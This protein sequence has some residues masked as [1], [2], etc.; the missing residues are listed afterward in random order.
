MNRPTGVTILAVLH[1]LGAGFAVLCGFGFLFGGT[2]LAL[3]GMSFPA[4]IAGFWLAVVAASFFA[5]AVLAVLV[6]VGL[7]RLR[8]W[9]RLVSIVLAGLGLLFAVLGVSSALLHFSVFLTIREVL[10]AV[11]YLWIMTYLLK[12]HVKQAFGASG[13]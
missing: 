13:S 8:S 5:G 7:L 10:V 1:F 11:L 6:G 2:L 3:L 12:P 9:A 4:G